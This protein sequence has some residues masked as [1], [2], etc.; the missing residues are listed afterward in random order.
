MSV[1]TAC[2]FIGAIAVIVLL[3]VFLQDNEIV[4]R[5]LFV[6]VMCLWGGIWWETLNGK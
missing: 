2:I 4:N 5:L 3:G 1:K 6:L